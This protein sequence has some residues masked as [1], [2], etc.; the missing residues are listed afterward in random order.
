MARKTALIKV[1]GDLY[2]NKDFIDWVRDITREYFVVICVG[3]G[4]QINKAF[5]EKDILPEYGSFGRETKDFTERQL[6]RDIL[7]TNQAELQDLLADKG[8]IATVVIP[9]LDIG[10]VLCHV[11]GDIFILTA[12]LGF[13]KIYVVTLWGRLKEKKEQFKTYPKIE[14]ISF[15]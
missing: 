10:S 5:A 4:T 11:N 1:S 7:E 14:V 9:I 13:D 3:G 2:S 15:G 8:I 6:A 12:Y